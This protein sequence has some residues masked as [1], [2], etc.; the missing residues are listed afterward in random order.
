MPGNT[1]DPVAVPH[2]HRIGWLGTTALAMGGSN[3]SLFLIGALFAGQGGIPGQGSAAVPLLILGLLLSYAAAF[4]WT[5]LVLMSPRRVGGIAAACTEAFRP[6]S[7]VLSTLTATCYWW[8]WVPT[9][10]V[11][12]LL[13]AAAINQWILPWCQVPAIA[14]ALVIGFT[15]LNLCGIRWVT[16]AALPI[17]AASAALAFVAALAPALTGAVD[18]HRAASFHLTTPFD[19]WFGQVTSLMAGLYLVGFAAPAFEA[20]TCHVGETVDPVRNVPRAMLASGA[21]AAVYFVVLP[22]VWLGVLGPDPMGGD[23]AQELGP[24]FAPLFGA[25]GKSAA[26]G[27]M[28]LNMFHGTL[29]PLAGAARTLSQIAEDGLAPRFLSRRLRGTDVPWVATVLTAG[30]AIAFLLIGDPIWLIAAANFTYLIG[31]CL[32]SVAVWLL[33][34]NAPD[35]ERPYRAPASTIGLGLAA[36]CVWGVSALLG[37]QQFG[38]PTVVFGLVMA[39]SGAGLYAWRKVEDRRRA[40]LPGFAH[41]LHTKLTGSMLLVLGLDAAGYIVAVGKLPQDS[42]ALVVALEDIFVA[43]ALLTISVGIVLPGIISH[44]A[45][46]VS[47][48]ARRL[49]S[50]TLR[51]FSRAM[52]SLGRGDLDAA[53]ASLNIAPVVSHARDELGAM[54]ESFNLMQEEVLKAAQGLDGAREGLG[55]ARA[56]LTEVNERLR[57]KVD[58]QRRLTDEL[59]L[60]KDAAEAGN[61]AKSEFL[62]VISHE[63]R[64]PMNGIIG[65]SELLLDADLPDR[66][67]RFASTILASAGA[68]VAIIDDILDFSKMEAGRFDLAEQVFDLPRLVTGVTELFTGKLGGRPVVLTHR[69]EA[70][71]AGLFRADPGRLRQV[72]VN[73]VG[74]AVKFTDEGSVTLT[75]SRSD[76]AG[77]G[78]A[79]R[80]SVEDTG[81]GVPLDRQPR[82]FAMFSQA[83]ASATRRYGGTGLGLAISK[84]IVEQMGGDIGFKSR[85][86]RGSTFWFTLPLPRADGAPADP[87]VDACEASFVADGL[88]VLVAEDDAVNRDVAFH[89]LTRLGH[90]VTLVSNG[91]EAVERV[92]AEAFDVVLMDVQMPVMDGLAATRAIREL[93]G[94]RG[95]TPVIALTADAMRGDRE[96]FLAAGMDDVLPKPFDRAALRS[97]LASIPAR[98]AATDETRVSP[99][100]A[101]AP[102]PGA[103]LPNSDA[104]VTAELVADMGLAAVRRISVSFMS[105]LDATLPAI[106][107]ALGAGDVGAARMGAHRLASAA[108]NLGFVR[109]AASLSSLEQACRSGGSGTFGALA[110]AE[111]AARDLVATRAD[112]RDAA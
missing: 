25:F 20:A 85:E 66:D 10:G 15:A 108:G 42:S 89:T 12:A 105:D 32:P 52:E 43:V 2:P 53:H 47:A 40:G 93:P 35:A 84:R 3:Q 80:F 6:Y 34:R 21:M 77:S 61:R 50:G 92:A 46:E 33:R 62:A 5:E 63:I 11:T 18:W 60:A 64:T 37:F 14:C 56:E 4:G 58:K 41:T 23:L 27:F 96:R 49:A 94:A 83:D 16:R 99:R 111:A 81:I 31:I 98:P 45:D 78:T 54:A 104:S 67:R 107:T 74:N 112:E 19:G 73:L 36:A 102:E 106:A 76:E 13:S 57:R 79:V 51:D 65:M 72:L 75:V 82:L 55:R 90:R 109:L 88:G 86:G 7:D 71:A 30:F 95:R 29:Q 38:L 68:L 1:S 97:L 103:D 101:A 28:M 59:V 39:Y 87:A 110:S 44:S 91:R 24:T 48:A 70:G 100:D 8:G 17:A 26:I 22:V 69:V 9:C